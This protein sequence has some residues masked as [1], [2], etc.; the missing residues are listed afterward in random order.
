M[1]A[2]DYFTRWSEA[3]ACKNV[4]QEVVIDMTKR[5]ITHFGIP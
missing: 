4:D 3:I 2:T 1:I 5:L